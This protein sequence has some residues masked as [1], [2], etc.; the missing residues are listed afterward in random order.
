MK[1]QS[2][3]NAIYGILSKTYP[4]FENSDDP[5]MANGLS[6]TP[7]KSLVSAA[8]STMTTTARVISAAIPLY[9]KVDSFEELLAMDDEELRS[10][11]KPVAHYNR[12]VRSLKK[13]CRQ[14]VEDFD[15]KIPNSREE[16]LSLNGIGEKCS[17][18]IM[19]FQFGERTIAVDTHIHRLLNR[20]GIVKTSN[21]KATTREINSMTP[22]R[23]KKHA[24]EWLI[25]HG[26][27]VCVARNP[28]CNECV[29]RSRCDYN[30]TTVGSCCAS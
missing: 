28:R 2:D 18:L 23:F 13:M 12:K 25:Q 10:I 6:S 1:R 22:M 11:I 29:I 21:T 26:M 8:L 4:T 15:G 3:L 5:W 30:R 24:H 20:L 7:F 16:L 19:N 17:R 9:E 14:I 27:N